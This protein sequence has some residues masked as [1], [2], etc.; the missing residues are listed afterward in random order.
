MEKMPTEKDVT[1]LVT[2]LA[3]PNDATVRLAK[4][5]LKQILQRYPCYRDLLSK[6]VDP[7]IAI[8][9]KMFLEETRLEEL[10]ESFRDLVAWGKDLDLE[11]GAILLAQSAYPSLQALT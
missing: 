9:A 8:Q 5:Q 3:D 2:F 10:K 11:T 6:S 1:V 7:A 4:S